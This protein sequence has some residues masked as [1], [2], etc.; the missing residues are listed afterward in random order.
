M[1]VARSGGHGGPSGG[2]ECA[3]ESSGGFGV[4]FVFA[5]AVAAYAAGGAEV[6]QEEEEE[7]LVVV[8]RVGGS[9]RESGQRRASVVIARLERYCNNF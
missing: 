5:Q 8:M 1:S 6:K 7:E 4:H 9:G 3:R 2:G